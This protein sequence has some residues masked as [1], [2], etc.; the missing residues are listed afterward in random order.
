MASEGSGGVDGSS[1]TA[2]TSAAE[3]STDTSGSSGSSG[4]SS[5]GAAQC[6]NGIVEDPEECDDESQQCRSDCLLACRPTTTAEFE[7][8]RGE[9]LW[10]IDLGLDDSG[11]IVGVGRQ[12]GLA[13]VTSD[14][15]VM[16][17]TA[18]GE[19]L[20]L[21][22]YDHAGSFDFGQAVSVEPDGTAYIAGTVT[23]GDTQAIVLRSDP[24]GALSW[25]HLPVATAD[26][27]SDGQGIAAMPG[28]GFVVSGGMGLGSGDSDL[29]A[30]HY[31]SERLAWTSSYNSDPAG[32]AA[33]D[34]GGPVAVD[35]QGRVYVAGTQPSQRGGFGVSDPAVVAFGPGGAGPLWVWSEWLEA[36]NLD[37]VP[38]GIESDGLGRTVA[39][40]RQ[41]HGSST[42]AHFLVVVLEADGTPV[43]NLDSDSLDDQG[44][45]NPT[46]LATDASGRVYV[47][48]AHTSSDADGVFLVV[49]DSNADV[50][51]DETS[52]VDAD[53]IGA[54]TVQD[55]GD[56]VTAGWAFDGVAAATSHIVGYRGFDDM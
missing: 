38:V 42:S 9:G 15:F 20:G 26:V 41:W 34:A 47:F 50:L 17:I 52:N 21:E 32:L 24:G 31:D 6:G 2:P 35:P 22:T 18:G 30:S 3:A 36:T 51:C 11:T 33:N 53:E 45:R 40:F 55:S 13:D 23:D 54:A 27:G 4:S 39:L 28:G 44:G 56:L 29:F 25:N 43:F 8:P 46:A 1:S 37:L 5:D 7:D 10:L 48:G 12:G 14:L 16:R 49:L 19:L